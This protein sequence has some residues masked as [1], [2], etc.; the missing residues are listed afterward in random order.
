MSDGSA[1]PPDMPEEEVP[2]NDELQEPSTEKEPSEE[3]KAPSRDEPEPSHEAVGIG[4][5][6]RPQVEPEESD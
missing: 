5:V 6:G 2:S 1:A 4:V 3:P